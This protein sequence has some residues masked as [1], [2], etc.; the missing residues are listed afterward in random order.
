[1][2]PDWTQLGCSAQA[3]PLGTHKGPSLGAHELG[4]HSFTVP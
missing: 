1:M 2:I 3:R 4:L